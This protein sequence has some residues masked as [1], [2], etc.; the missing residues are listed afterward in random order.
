MKLE[1]RTQVEALRHGTGKTYEL[2]AGNMRTD[3]QIRSKSKRVASELCGPLDS[4]KLDRQIQEKGADGCNK[5]KHLQTY[6]ATTVRH[7]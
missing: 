5:H 7:E 3:T 6:V 4:V 1:A 2:A